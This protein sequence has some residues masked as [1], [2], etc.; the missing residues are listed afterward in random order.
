MNNATALQ[1][2][3]APKSDQL[4]ADDLLVGGIVIIIA[5]V[6]INLG[7]EQKI[8]INYH[9]DNG[10]PWKPSKGM[11]RVLTMILGGDPD[12]WIGE[13]V[14]LYRDETVSFGKD[15]N[16]GGIRIAGMSAVKTRTILSITTAKGKKSQVT[17]EPIV[18]AGNQQQ[19]RAPA[20]QA[21]QQTEQPNPKRDWAIKLKAAVNYGSIAVDEVWATVPAEL[22]PEME[23]FYKERF[24]MAQAFDPKDDAP[25]S[26]QQ[27]QEQPAA[28]IGDF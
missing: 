26:D 27:Q 24:I 3:L 22:Q 4:N 28:D 13:T 11:G 20:Q 18:V 23:A 19:Q 12:K 5:K 1:Q 17:I 14:E 16:C 15:K 2:A 8:I 7:S 10:K 6:N 9:G 21:P 25:V